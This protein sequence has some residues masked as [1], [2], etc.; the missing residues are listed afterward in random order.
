MKKTKFFF[1]LDKEEEWLN[2]MAQQGL[3]LSKKGIKYTFDQV[4]DKRLIK[5][6]YRTFKS[7]KDLED[8]ILLFEDSGWKHLA[9]NKNSGKQYFMKKEAHANEDIFSDQRSKAERYKRMSDVWLNS[10]IAYIPI[11]VLLY[12][13]KMIDIGSI[14]NPRSLYLTPGLWELTGSSFWKAFLFET[15]FALGRGFVWLLFP[16]LIILYIVFIIKARM[17]Y[18]KS[19]PD[20]DFKG[21]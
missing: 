14:L 6:D 17:E 5:I 8:Y 2:D 4:N 15:P 19:V 21:Y 12:Q 11:V 16:I 10:A 3:V 7:K 13:M 20:N 9:G 1:N 18:K